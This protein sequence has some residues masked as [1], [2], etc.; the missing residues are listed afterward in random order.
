M[1][2][3]K[4][5]KIQCSNESNNLIIMCDVTVVDCPLFGCHNPLNPLTQRKNTTIK[6]TCEWLGTPMVTI[7]VDGYTMLIP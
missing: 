6:A 1:D 4:N 7:I 5:Y 3:N 2:T